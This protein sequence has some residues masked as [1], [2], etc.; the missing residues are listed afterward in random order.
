[1]YFLFVNIKTRYKKQPQNS[2]NSTIDDSLYKFL[3][4]IQNKLY[5]LEF[6]KLAK[7]IGCII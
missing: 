6:W 7:R 4:I 2:E 3:G 1:M 5:L